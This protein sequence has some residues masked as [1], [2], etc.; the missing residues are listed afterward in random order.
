MLRYAVFS[1]MILAIFSCAIE[2][3]RTEPQV[4][5]APQA[6]TPPAKGLKKTITDQD[7]KKRDDDAELK[8]R[9]VIL[10]ILDKKNIRSEAILTA[11]ANAFMDSL[12]QTGELIAIDSKVLKIDLKKYIKNSTYDMKAIAQDA[13]KV[14]VSAL[15]EP[16]IVDMR[17][18]HEDPNLVD[19]SSSLKSRPLV[20]EVVVQARMISTHTDKELFNTVKTVTIDDSS[21]AVAEN[22]T[23]D[24]FFSKNSELTEILIKDAFMDFRTKLVESLKQI[25]WEGRIAA[26]NGDKIYLNVGRISG[27]Q[28]GDILKV[29]EDGSEIYDTELGYHVGQVQGRVKGTL[30]IV[31]FFGQDG[32]VGVIHSGA[33]F[34]ENDRIEV[35]Q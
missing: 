23:S 25:T 17:F 35:Y 6:E 21:S 3:K 32:S 30:E 10:P 1:A 7:L 4:A 11:A 22:I 19:N 8:K 9:V 24:N 2:T 31:S 28:V 16:R 14:G 26:L 34:K 13:A 33:G 18:Q 27:V 12:N 20:F 29:V 15:L 5:P